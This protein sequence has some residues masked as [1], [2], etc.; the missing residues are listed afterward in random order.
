[1]EG[2]TPLTDHH[3]LPDH[4]HE[5]TTSSHQDIFIHPPCQQKKTIRCVVWDP[6]IANTKQNHDRSRMQGHTESTTLALG[7]LVSLG[8]PWVQSLMPRQR[9]SKQSGVVALLE[10]CPNALVTLMLR[11]P[12]RPPELAVG[13]C[14]WQEG[15]GAKLVAPSGGDGPNRGAQQKQGR[16]RETE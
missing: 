10:R 8:W 15:S 6:S 14:S 4:V 16:E 2:R 12:P 13:P 7:N 9:A 1:M 11:P 5:L 3:S